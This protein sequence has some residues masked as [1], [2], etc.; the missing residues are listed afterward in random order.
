MCA[1][2]LT[3]R[4]VS[5]IEEIDGEIHLSTACTWDNDIWKLK[6]Y[7]EKAVADGVLKEEDCAYFQIFTIP[8]R[9]AS[10]AFNTDSRFGCLQ[11]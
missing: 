9:P 6:P 2:D 5:P 3:D 1:T 11:G 8:N 7:F 4:V 10:I